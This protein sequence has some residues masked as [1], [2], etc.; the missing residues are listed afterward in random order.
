MAFDP[1]LPAQGAKIRSAE[2]R[3]QFNGLIDG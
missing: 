2:L 3:G 1:D